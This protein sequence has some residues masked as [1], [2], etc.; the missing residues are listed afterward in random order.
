MSVRIDT[1]I[2]FG[3]PGDRTYLKNTT[4]KYV[5]DQIESWRESL[6]EAA[7]AGRP[8]A[9]SEFMYLHTEKDEEGPVNGLIIVPHKI[10]QM[11]VV[12]VALRPDESM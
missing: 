5:L 2:S 6:R 1:V 9:D 7:I 10:T 3:H 8:V 4:P 11:F 12:E